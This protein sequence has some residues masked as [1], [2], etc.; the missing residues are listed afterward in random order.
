MNMNDRTYEL[1]TFWL[2]AAHLVVSLIMVICNWK[3]PMKTSLPSAKKSS[4]KKGKNV[5]TETTSFIE[6]YVSKICSLLKNNKLVW[7]L[8]LIVCIAVCVL[9]GLCI[10]G[11][12]EIE[13]TT[14]MNK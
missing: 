1:I 2:V 4:S 9:L 6:N 7:S 11:E 13:V 5:L 8:S 14:E 10:W 3:T 12:E